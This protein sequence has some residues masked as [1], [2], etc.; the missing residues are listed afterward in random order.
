MHM[1]TKHDIFKERLTGWL[2]ANGNRTERRRI[3][4]HVCF[5]AKVHP[6]SVARGFRR[7][8]MRTTSRERRPGRRI[9]YG[10]DVTA[11]LKALWD[12]AGEPCAENLRPLIVEYVT[13]FRR[14]HAWAFGEETTTKLFEMSLGTLKKRV[15]K[16]KRMSFF[17]RSKGTT[18][19]SAIHSIIPVRS[20]PWDDAVTGTVQIDTVAHC[21]GST[22]GDYVYTV[23]STDVPTLWG[24]RRAQW[25]KGQMAT[26]QSMEAMEADTP[27][28]I[29]ERH[30][31]S[32]SEFVNWHCLAWSKARGQRLTR[33]RPNRKNDNCFVEE[34]NGHVVRRYIGHARYD[35]PEFVDAINAVYDVLTPYLNHFVASRRTVSKERVGAHWKIVRERIA[36]T[37]YQRVLERHNV[38]D[39]VKDRLKREHAD[40]SPLTLKREIDQR[41]GILF[42][43]LQRHVKSNSPGK[44]R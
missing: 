13:I 2:K 11:A 37:P 23:N 7:A 25:N 43:L 18:S 38:S 44:L 8:Q 42:N 12:I 27:F 21:G 40:M 29:Q 1:T 4:D 33:S 3:A 16:F 28:P 9:L 19:P 20:G 30:P 32:G 41:L 34:R 10:P 26:V 24:T 14:D 6:K 31:D 22:A 39:D 17:S 15:S 5:V 35:A 36:K